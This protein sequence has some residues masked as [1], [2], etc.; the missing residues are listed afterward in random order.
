MLA[1]VLIN[2][3]IIIFLYYSLFW[4]DTRETLWY[5]PLKWVER[6]FVYWGM[7]H[8]WHMFSPPPKADLQLEAEILFENGETVLWKSTHWEKSGL[9]P[10]FWHMRRQ[11]YKWGVCADKVTACRAALTHFLKELY[12]DDSQQ[13]VVINLYMIHLE[14]PA[15][16]NAH[17]VFSPP[18]N[19]LLVH[20]WMKKLDPHD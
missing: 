16:E 14:V 4:S 5:A 2:I 18:E 3:F 11:I 9:L 1:Y 10:S 17:P 20:K 8:A 13:P 7:D 6:R 19:R 15:P 12:T